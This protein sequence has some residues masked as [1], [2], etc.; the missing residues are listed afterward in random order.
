MSGKALVPD[1]MK[2]IRLLLIPITAAWITGGL[3]WFSHQSACG[4]AAPADHANSV[5]SAAIIHLGPSTPATPDPTADQGLPVAGTDQPVVASASG[6]AALVSSLVIPFGKNKQE[7]EL[8]EDALRWSDAMRG[9]LLTHPAD[10]IIVSGHT[11]ADGDADLNR[12]LSLQRAGI[13]KARLVELGLPEDRINTLGMGPDEPVADNSTSKGKAMN[14][15]VEIHLEA[16][17]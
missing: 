4:C 12:R 13:V 16:Q 5:T 8:N 3:W 10:R 6:D 14:R 7:L 11:D 1:G 9:H 2:G 17:P 15:R